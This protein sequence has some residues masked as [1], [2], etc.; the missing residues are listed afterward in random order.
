MQS[1]MTSWVRCGKNENPFSSLKASYRS[2]YG[3]QFPKLCQ[4]NKSP[5]ANFSSSEYPQPLLALAGSMIDKN[6]EWLECSI[7][8][9]TMNFLPRLPTLRPFLTLT[10]SYKMFHSDLVHSEQ[11]L[12]KRKCTKTLSWSSVR[13]AVAEK[14]HI[15][16][17]PLS[18][19]SS[20]T[21]EKKT[22]LTLSLC[23]RKRFLRKPD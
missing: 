22:K 17:R 5:S 1:L 15:V 16:Q 8:C 7:S 12:Q 21:E 4:K 14:G 6:P 13:V 11:Y 2:T 18:F 9:G 23:S 20:P 3:F 10:S 19:L